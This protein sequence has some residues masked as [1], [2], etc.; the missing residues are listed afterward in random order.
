M[1]FFLQPCE[2]KTF[3]ISRGYSKYQSCHCF[4]LDFL[5]SRTMR[6]KLR[7]INYPVCDTLLQQRKQTKFVLTWLRYGMIMPTRAVRKDLFYASREKH[8]ICILEYNLAIYV[9]LLPRRLPRA[10]GIAQWLNLCLAMHEVLGSIQKKENGEEG[11]RRKERRKGGKG[12]EGRRRKKNL[13]LT[14]LHC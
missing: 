14:Q 5:A 7:I 4:N 13:S 2:D 8:A 12:R 3:I 11:R 6:N 9:K 1:A 10:R